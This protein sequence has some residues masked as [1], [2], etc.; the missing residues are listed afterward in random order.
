MA[1]YV[2]AEVSIRLVLVTQGM[3]LS[4]TSAG[5]AASFNRTGGATGGRDRG[6]RG[7]NHK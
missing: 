1:S 3:F 7:A 6:E 2:L 4:N 5:D